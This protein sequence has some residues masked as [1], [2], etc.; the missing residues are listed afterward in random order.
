MIL[1]YKWRIIGG[2]CLTLCVTMAIMSTRL[3]TPDINPWVLLAYWG[4]FLV[5]LL[6]TLYTAILDFRYTRM[7]YKM[8]EREMFHDTFM[9]P[10]FR[11]AIEDAARE[12]AAPSKNDEN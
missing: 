12:K 7:R 3:A 6:T 11:K 1:P 10:E 9:T 8:T 4:L 5:L 2:I